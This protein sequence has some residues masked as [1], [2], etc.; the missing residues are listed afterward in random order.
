MSYMVES[1]ASR[2]H[3]KARRTA[4]TL[5]I[6]LGLVAAAFYYAA[7]YW[8]NP[9]SSAA[10]ACPTA[11]ATTAKAAAKAGTKV[12]AKPAA[13]TPNQITINVYNA[14]NRAG[15]AA[16]TAAQIKQR[17]YVVGTVSNDPLN[18]TIPGTAELRFGAAGAVQANAVKGLVAGMTAVKDTRQDATVDIVLGEQFKVLAVTPA[19]KATAGS[20]PC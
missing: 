15:L 13:P 14:T 3:R 1:A 8:R 16:E 19:G 2:R 17:G 11:T 5:V 18:K 9:G 12:A 20:N 6:V 7:S 4:I 10:S